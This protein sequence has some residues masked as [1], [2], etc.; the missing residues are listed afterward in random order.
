MNIEKENK[1]YSNERERNYES[2]E[3]RE[4]EI[5]EE[6]K[7]ASAMEKADYLVKEVKTSKKQMQN[8]V[9]HI[10]QVKQAIQKLRAQLDLVEEAVDPNSIEQDKKK[11]D[12][13]KEKI[14]QYKDEIISM[15]EDLIIEQIDIL[16]QENNSNYSDAELRKK[17]QE[18]VD[19]MIEAIE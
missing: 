19:Q 9:L 8:I 14:S 5:D 16:Q 2:R 12:E 13:L 10:N 11:V 1:F 15:R 18:K 6:L 4:G 7:K 3:S 17:A